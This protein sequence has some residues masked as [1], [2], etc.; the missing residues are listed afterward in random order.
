MSIE[1]QKFGYPGGEAAPEEL[2]ALAD[3]FKRIAEIARGAGRKGQPLSRAPYRLLA[4]HAVE[5][6][7]NAFLI[8][9]GE[10]HDQVRGLQHNFAKRL[11]FVSSHRLILTKKTQ[12][13]LETLTNTREYLAS[14]YDPRASAVSHL[15]RLEATVDEVAEKVRKIITLRA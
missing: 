14:R 4:I 3:E 11:D 2:L 10:P 5:L 6:Y 13:H 12:R 15:N 8:S 9:V 1:G 7:L